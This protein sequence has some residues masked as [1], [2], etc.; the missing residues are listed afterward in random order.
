MKE[1]SSFLGKSNLT[2]R[3]MRDVVMKTTEPTSTREA[4]EWIVKYYTVP[5]KKADLKQVAKNATQMNA[6]ERTLILSILKDF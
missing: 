6:E 3:E 1:P 5:M 2:K 4:T